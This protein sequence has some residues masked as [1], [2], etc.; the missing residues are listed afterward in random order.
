MRIFVVP[1]ESK[2]LKGEKKT[3]TE[4]DGTWYFSRSAG[5]DGDL[6]NLLPSTVYPTYVLMG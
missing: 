1:N 5:S 6:M 2:K 3:F 4:S